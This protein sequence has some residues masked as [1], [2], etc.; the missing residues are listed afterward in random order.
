MPYTASGDDSRQREPESPF[1]NGN[2][3][4]STG[5][6]GRPDRDDLS[7]LQRRAGRI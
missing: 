3:T 5:N 6:A 1:V 7:L 4:F 2:M